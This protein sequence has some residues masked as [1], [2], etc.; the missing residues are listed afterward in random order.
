MI[1]PQT[2]PDQ[3]KIG[4]SVAKRIHLAATC[5]YR[6]ASDESLPVG[7]LSHWV[8]PLAG[9]MINSAKLTVGS[10]VREPPMGFARLNPSYR[11]GRDL[12]F[13]VA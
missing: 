9:P 1:D 3:G 2:R 11:V 4:A 7:G 6:R 10:A 13:S 5:Q 8:R 12:H